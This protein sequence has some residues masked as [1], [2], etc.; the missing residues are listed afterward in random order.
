[1]NDRK[2]E[3]IERELISKIEKFSNIINGL[4]SNSAFKA[5]IEDFRKNIEIIDSSWHLIPLTDGLKLMELRVT[6]LAAVTLVNVLDGYKNDLN[7]ATKMLTEIKHPDKIQ[8]SYYDN[9]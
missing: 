8:G 2:I 5:L 7:N 9:E 1:M 4:E 6:K 3:D